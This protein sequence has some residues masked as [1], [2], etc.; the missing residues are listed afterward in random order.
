MPHS[1]EVDRIVGDIKGVNDSIIAHAQTVSIAADQTMMRETF[2]A[3]SYLI[4]FGFDSLPDVTW[5]SK[6]S[7]IKSRVI[8]LKS[9]TA[10]IRAC[11]R[12]AVARETFLAQT[13]G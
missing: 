8:N 6:K 12:A 1:K 5:Q 7:A 11:G 10:A 4:D 13:P 3:Q 2:Q 9:G